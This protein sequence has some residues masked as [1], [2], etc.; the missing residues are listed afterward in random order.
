MQRQR[1]ILRNERFNTIFGTNKGQTNIIQADIVSLLVY[2]EHPWQSL[3]AD[4]YEPGEIS[5]RLP[6][7]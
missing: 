2:E 7:L 5:P 4:P 3:G 6:K 1:W